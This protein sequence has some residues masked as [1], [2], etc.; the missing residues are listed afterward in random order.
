MKKIVFAVMAML[1]M[2]S[3]FAANEKASTMD[4]NKYVM[5]VNPVNIARALEL[6]AFQYEEV[7]AGEETFAE[8]TRW[9]S[10]QK[11]D[12]A[13]QAQ[14]N[15]AIMRN[16]KYMRDVLSKEQY[17][18]YVMFINITLANRGIAF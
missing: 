4:A 16:L 3:A 17:Q 13:R 2:T 9:A 11:T 14:F 12:E 6:R 8:E 18:K 7:A 5:D 10:R 1:S 15:K